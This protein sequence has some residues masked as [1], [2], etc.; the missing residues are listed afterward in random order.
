MPT[1]S[2]PDTLAESYETMERRHT[3][4]VNLE[5]WELLAM[6]SLAHDESIARVRLNMMKSLAGVPINDGPNAAGAGMASPSSSGARMTS[7]GPK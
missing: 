4:A 1:A 6:H 2:D 3:L 7:K 5:S